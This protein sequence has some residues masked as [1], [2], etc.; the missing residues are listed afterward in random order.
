M[1]ITRLPSSSSVI[2][3]VQRGTASIAD[4]ATTTNVT[5]TAVD[6]S[7]TMCNITFYC[8]TANNEPTMMP[9]VRLTSTTNLELKRNTGTA[10]QTVY[11]SWEVIEYV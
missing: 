7:K 8:S 10:G 2:K 6:M 11:V 4:T 3:S 5:I 9:W 1:G